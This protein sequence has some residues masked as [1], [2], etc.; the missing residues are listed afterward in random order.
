MDAHLEKLWNALEKIDDHVVTVR[1]WGG[2][3][4]GVLTAGGRLL[5]C[6]N[7]GSAAEAQHLTAELVG[8]FRDDRRPY[9]A[10]PLHADGSSLTAIANDFGPEE[11]YA[12]QVR[13]HGRPGDVLLCLSTSGGSPNV[14]AAARAAQELGIVSWS[15]TGP[16]PNPLAD[17]CDEAVAVPAEETA[18]VQEVHLAMIH[19]L[20][21]AL[22]DAL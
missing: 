15:M 16:A 8:R 11:M 6:G 4:A 7:G 12:R 2:K 10:I 13:A 18:T 21:D 14:L 22:E 3:L 5:A 20:C 17:L 1:A 19:L 9:A